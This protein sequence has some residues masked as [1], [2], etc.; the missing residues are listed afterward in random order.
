[1]FCRALSSSQFTSIHSNS[2]HVGAMNLTKHKSYHRP[3][4]LSSRPPS[5]S[6]RNAPR[7]HSS[8]A[9][10]TSISSPGLQPDLFS[11]ELPSY[12]PIDSSSSSFTS[13]PAADSD[14]SRKSSDAS[15]STDSSNS[16]R[17]SSNASNASNA[18]NQRL[19]RFN[20]SNSSNSSLSSLNSRTASSYATLPTHQNQLSAVAFF[21]SQQYSIFTTLESM[22]A[23]AH[24]ILGKYSNQPT[25]LRLTLECLEAWNS[26]IFQS[27]VTDS[28]ALNVALSA[29]PHAQQFQQHP[30]LASTEP[31]PSLNHLI[32]THVLTLLLNADGY[33]ESHSTRTDLFV[34]GSLIAGNLFCVSCT[35]YFSP[36]FFS[37]LI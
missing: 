15:A 9:Y 11:Q 36:F 31:H 35:I 1:M 22:L 19:K 23:F 34:R 10:M 3:L 6:S 7:S 30:S 13:D 12:L 5:W 8:Q 25:V 28:Q 27:L 4:Y 16:S 24:P 14:P 29:L 20:S 33:F 18:S 37:N 26:A 17:K 21:T 2:L 32:S